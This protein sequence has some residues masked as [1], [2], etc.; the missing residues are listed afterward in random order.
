MR[1]DFFHIASIIE[2]NTVTGFVMNDPKLP[3]YSVTGEGDP[4]IVLLHGAFGAK[5]YWR[6]QMAVLS[7][8]G[9]RVLAWDAPG[10]GLSPLPLP[11][12]VEIAAA[13][14][15]RLLAAA[16]GS[17]NVLLGHSFG[18]MIAQ[19]AYDLFPDRVAGM[20]LSATSAAFGRRDGEWQQK[21]VHDRVAP[22]D[23]GLTVAEYAPAFLK[24]MMA[25]GAA[26]PAVDL[27]VATV[28]AMREET[29]RAAIAAVAG[30][31][32]RAVL[33]K[34]AVPTLCI[35]GELDQTAPAAV[36]EKMASRIR[37][38]EFA[39]MNGAG[40]FAWAEQADRFNATLLDFLRRHFR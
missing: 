20:V 18:G 2:V 9:Y 7:D 21:F 10:Y 40:H 35:A 22:L 36:M 3:D 34:I 24:T 39:V 11:Y 16:G 13:S 32:G 27:V 19:R 12:S 31:E 6:T 37:G 5:E 4:T 8:A 30:Y 38:A 17:R 28:S 29:F 15:G 1:V 23:A 25:S 14:L 26:G 33:P